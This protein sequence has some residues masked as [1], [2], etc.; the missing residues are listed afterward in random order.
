MC[1]CACVNGPHLWLDGLETGSGCTLPLTLWLLGKENEWMNES[2][3]KWI[4]YSFIVLVEF[5][6]G[7]DSFGF[8]EIDTYSCS[9]FNLTLAFSDCLNV[10]SS[11]KVYLSWSPTEPS[12]SSESCLKSHCL[13]NS[14]IISGLTHL[15]LLMLHGFISPAVC[16][17]SCGVSVCLC[18]CQ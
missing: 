10:Q 12:A 9:D 3:Q 8:P 17:H 11:F 4:N 13:S 7:H 16:C 1:A 6:T 15:S 14:I 18:C 5:E 2:H